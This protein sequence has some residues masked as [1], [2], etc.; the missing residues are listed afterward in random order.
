MATDGRGCD[1][2]DKCT[3]VHNYCDWRIDGKVCGGEHK[4]ADPLW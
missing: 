1:Y 3:K 2:G 4:R